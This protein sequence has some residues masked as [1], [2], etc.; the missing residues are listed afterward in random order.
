MGVTKVKSFKK[1]FR[2]ILTTINV[3]CAVGTV[4]SVLTKKKAYAGIFAAIG[5][6]SLAAAFLINK[7]EKAEKKAE[8]EW[9]AENFMNELF[10]DDEFLSEIDIQNEENIPL[11]VEEEIANC[12]CGSLSQDDLSVAIKNLEDA[13]KELGDALAGLESDDLKEME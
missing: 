3:V 9:N 2:P 11:K 10:S 1:S 12:D 4:V 13:G 7:K 8:E 5:F 6:L